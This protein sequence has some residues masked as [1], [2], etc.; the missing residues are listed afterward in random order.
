MLI[1]VSAMSDAGF[2]VT[3]HGNKGEQKIEIHPMRPYDLNLNRLADELRELELTTSQ[4][5]SMITT[6]IEDVHTF[7]V[8]NA[9]NRTAGDR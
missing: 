5:G 9:I 2:D 3:I 4:A 7:Q 6:M 8:V 1:N